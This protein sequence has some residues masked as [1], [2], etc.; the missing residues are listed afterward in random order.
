MNTNRDYFVLVSTDER[1]EFRGINYFTNYRNENILWVFT[2]IEEALRFVA[3]RVD[4]NQAYLD[5][6]ENSVPDR[7]EGAAE[8]E[9]FDKAIR[10]NF[11]NLTGIAREMNIDILALDPGSDDPA[12]RLFRV[13][14][15]DD[16]PDTLPYMG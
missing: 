2:S 13:R 8:T 12:S 4:K 9:L 14:K 15:D 1:G 10:L 6:L 7:T 16:S 11:R 5:L 3:R